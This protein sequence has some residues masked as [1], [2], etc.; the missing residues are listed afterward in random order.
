MFPRGG[1]RPTRRDVLV[2]CFSAAC[3][4]VWSQL[5]PG[6]EFRPHLPHSL[7]SA[8]Y[9]K[10]YRSGS[11]GPVLAPIQDP[12]YPD[13]L[14]LGDRRSSPPQI[15]VQVPSLLPS[16]RV[17]GHAPGWTLFDNLYMHNG[18][19]LII[20]DEPVSSFPERRLMTSTGL[21]PKSS[22]ARPASP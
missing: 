2:A 15:P 7:A 22:M 6:T 13:G 18:T 19:L 10:H 16:T 11:P 3:V 5:N 9:G 12:A 21:C 8:G 4:L 20:S 1:F 17:L 14:V